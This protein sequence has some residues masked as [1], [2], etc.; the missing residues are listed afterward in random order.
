MYAPVHM[1]TYIY[2]HTPV[3]IAGDF[4]I[5]FVD[6]LRVSNVTNFY[7][8]RLPLIGLNYK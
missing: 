2:I 6:L 4:V 1:H 8:D 7:Y 5:V 3:H